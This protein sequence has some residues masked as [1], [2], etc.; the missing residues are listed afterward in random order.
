MS[1]S[2]DGLRLLVSTPVGS[3]KVHFDECIG[4][5]V[6]DELDLTEF[7]SECSLKVGWLFEVNE[8]GWKDL[9]SSRP[10]FYRGRLPR[11]REF[12]LVGTD[13]CVSVIAKAS[14]EVINN[15]L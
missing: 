1:Y 7:W 12:M 4:F 13:A 6:L 9:E 8:G 11:A 15:A 5:R 2:S 3:V 10:S 14:P